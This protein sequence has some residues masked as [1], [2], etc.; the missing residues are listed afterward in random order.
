MWFRIL[1]CQYQKASR[2]PLLGLCKEVLSRV[3]AESG[4]VFSGMGLSAVQIK[5]L[6]QLAASRPYLM[7]TF[8]E[9]VGLYPRTSTGTGLALTNRALE[10]RLMKPGV[11][12][13]N[14]NR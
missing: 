3:Y 12:E 14:W 9:I 6:K 4:T 8:V 7:S 13:M 1:L 5:A 2:R 11:F 10:P